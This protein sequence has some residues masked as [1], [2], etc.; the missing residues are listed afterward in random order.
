MDLQKYLN[1]MDHIDVILIIA[2]IVLLYIALSG[3][4]EYY[5]SIDDSEEMG[6]ND[7]NTPVVPSSKEQEPLRVY[8]PSPSEKGDDLP[9]V[10]GD[11]PPCE[12]DNTNDVEMAPVDYNTTSN[13][14]T[15]KQPFNVVGFTS[16]SDNMGINIQDM[17]K[18]LA[19][20]GMDVFN[21]SCGS[22]GYNPPQNIMNSVNTQQLQ[23][24]TLNLLQHDNQETLLDQD[25]SN[26]FFAHIGEELHDLR[27]GVTSNFGFKGVDTGEESGEQSGEQSGDKVKVSLVHAEWCGFC[28]KALPEWN[29]VKDD[30]H[31]KDING[32]KMHMEDFEEKEDA[33]LIGKG[34]KF[35]VDG[36]PTFFFTQV[37]DGVEQQPIKFNA[38]TYD[39]ILDKIKELLGQ[40]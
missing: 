16:H 22:I 12:Y 34:K 35:E 15:E 18:P 25:Q 13:N 14:L 19:A 2:V 32:F 31:G 37:R 10:G 28:K 27:G 20:L 23:M 3:N 33:H 4:F 17:D 30:Y 40:L 21:D 11:E 29:K 6:H 7:F 8:K 36:F 5:S 39:T 24:D 26:G 1:N 9:C 38:I